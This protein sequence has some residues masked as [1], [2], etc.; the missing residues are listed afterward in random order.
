[1]APAMA[2]KSTGATDPDGLR[3][4]RRK[5]S[6]MT[7]AEASPGSAPSAALPA[8]AA[9]V[10]VPSSMTAP[11]A[12]FEH[13]LLSMGCVS[14]GC[15]L[16]GYQVHEK[17]VLLPLLPLQALHARLPLLAAWFSGVSLLSLGPLLV[18]DALLEAPLPLAFVI[19]LAALHLAA[20][21]RAT[22]A[23][24]A[25]SLRLALQR[26]LGRNSAAAPAA[27]DLQRWLR[28]GA[29]ATAA[30]G[31]ALALAAALVPPPA[32]LPDLH[33]YANSV[34]CAALLAVALAVA[35]AVQFAWVAEAEAE[36]EA[37][38]EGGVKQL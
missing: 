18:K 5:S 38:G 37:A 21:G 27:A 16:A 24:E 4:R 3:G 2:P 13:L 31:L 23:D 19:A 14:L 34:V 30:L 32:R 11:P 29:I 20:G 7:A 8:A 25:A 33:A 17:S 12:L 28:R 36:A 35:T 9:P 22:G 26:M 15:F 1:M 10:A 6:S